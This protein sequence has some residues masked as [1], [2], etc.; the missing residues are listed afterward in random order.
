M[1]RE[2]Q[3]LQ[4]VA[5]QFPRSPHQINAFLEGDA[6]LIRLDNGQVLAFTVDSIVEEIDSGLYA[7][8]YLIGW[9]T[10]VAS[11][12]D[13]AAVGAQPIGLLLFQHF[14]PGL[15]N[16]FIEQLQQ[17]VQACCKATGVF[18]LGGDTNQADRL[19]VGAAAVGIIPDDPIVLRK[20]AEARD[21]LYA[22]YSMGQGS[23]FAF[24]RLFNGNG[25][26]IPYQP[27]PRLQEGRLVRK[28]GNCCIDT[29][30]GFFPAICNLMEINKLGVHLECTL[31]EILPPST[32]RLAAR[33]G[34][35]PWFFLAGPHGEFELLFSIPPER[36][37]G[38][39]AAA[40]KVDWQ[41][42]RIGVF[43]EEGPA[44]WSATGCPIDAFRIANAFFEAAGNPR[45]FIDT[46]TQI[47]QSW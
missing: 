20:G 25:A 8:P 47:P 9:M 24:Q 34:I 27:K 44:L 3:F 36:E 35:P 21:I 31:E 41:P 12:S 33:T 37:A 22:S 46:L 7:D 16:A 45:Q 11:L 28:Y 17:G 10:A 30:D 26:D 42:L 40:R 23:A 5:R 43:S 29:S 19:H 32:L 15:S 14:P 1:L 38:F 13:L 2:N 18:V 6:E 4:F 39:L